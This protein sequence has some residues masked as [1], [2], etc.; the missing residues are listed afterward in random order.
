VH[1]ADDVHG[2]LTVCAAAQR[3]MFRGDTRFSAL[4]HAVGGL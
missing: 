4:A 3:E 1:V 2:S